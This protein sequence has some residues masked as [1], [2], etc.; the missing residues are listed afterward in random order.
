M[1]SLTQRSLL[2]H[3]VLEDAGIMLVRVSVIIVAVARECRSF[4]RESEKEAR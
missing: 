4:R 1:G 3:V 2:A